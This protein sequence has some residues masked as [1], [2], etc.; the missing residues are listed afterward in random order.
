[1]H[2]FLWKVAHPSREC[3]PFAGNYAQPTGDCVNACLPSRLASFSAR[4]GYLTRYSR[5]LRA[6][7]LRTTACISSVLQGCLL[8]SSSASQKTEWLDAST[9]SNRRSRPL[10]EHGVQRRALGWIHEMFVL[11]RRA[12]CW[13]AIRSSPWIKMHTRAEQ[14]SLV[15]SPRIWPLS[16]SLSLSLSVHAGL[17]HLPRQTVVGLDYSTV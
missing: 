5:G 17:N 1:M 15:K 2:R 7:K 10:V 8:G 9:H 12:R 3:R 14:Q 4:N 16:Q 6:A 11:C 13:S